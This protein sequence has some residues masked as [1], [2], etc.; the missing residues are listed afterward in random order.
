MGGDFNT[1]LMLIKG[2]YSFYSTSL[3]LENL[4]EGQT[5]RREE[6]CSNCSVIAYSR[7]NNRIVKFL[8]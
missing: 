7:T 6:V 5:R 2:S 8:G 4:F 1:Q 3:V